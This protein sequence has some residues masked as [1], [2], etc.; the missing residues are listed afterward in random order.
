MNRKTD[1]EAVPR[2]RLGLRALE[3]FVATAREGSTRAAAHRVARSQSAASAALAELEA[4][5]GVAVFDRVGRRLQ[6]NENG[7]ALL[8]QALALLQQAQAIETLFAGAYDAPLRLAASFT[9]GEYLLPDLV[10]QWSQQRPGSL[11]RLRIGNTGDVLEAVAAFETDVGFIEGPQSHPDLSVR[12]WRMDQLVVVAA[13]RHPLAG[14]VASAAQLGA[15]TWVLRER[16]SG[17]R[18]VADAWLTRHLDRVHVG[19]ELGSTE[20]VKQVVAAGTG[21]TCL[22]RHAVSQALAGGW[23]VELR[24]PLPLAERPLAVVMHRAR[25]LGRTTAAFLEH[26]GAW[27]P[28]SRGRQAP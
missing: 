15:A 27:P 28:A 5:L 26:C 3:V 13:P 11:V 2:L 7:R 21:L 14:T 18:Q 25:P 12:P 1:H 17:T 10:S 22:S 9:V 16:G 24:T 8:P 23:L 6:L 19:Y 20:A 4:V